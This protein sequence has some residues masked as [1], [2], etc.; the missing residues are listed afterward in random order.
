MKKWKKLAENRQAPGQIFSYSTVDVESPEGD[1][2]GKFD[3]LRFSH[4]VNV[5]PITKNQEIVLIKQ[6]R[7]GNDEITLETPGGAFEPG[8]SAL[9]TAKRELAEETGYLSEDWLDLGSINPNPAFMANR[10]HIYLARNC[11]LGQ[12]QDLDE[13][14]DIEVMLLPLGQ[15]KEQIKQGSIDHALVVAA[16]HIATI[17]DSDFAKSL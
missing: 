11:E 16:I 2:N 6:Y 1:R 12:A 17:H 15:L 5:V 14:E 4:W 10:L 9:T 3:L 8:E 7:V 13:L